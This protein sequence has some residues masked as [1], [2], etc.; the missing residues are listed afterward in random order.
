M[1]MEGGNNFFTK[2]DW[3]G[4]NTFFEAQNGVTKTFF[5]LKI[6]GFPSNVVVNFGP[7]SYI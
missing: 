6:T 3:G 4:G 7:P 2:S 1:E 5:G